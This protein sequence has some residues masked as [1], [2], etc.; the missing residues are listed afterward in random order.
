MSRLS[1][2][3]WKGHIALVKFDLRA[4]EKGVVVSVPQI[5]CRY[6]RVVETD[7]GFLRVQIK[8]A[9]G[10]ASKSSGSAIVRLKR[11][12]DRQGALRGYSAHE[13]DALVLYLPQVDKLCWLEPK[14]FVDK[15]E[16]TIRYTESKNK[17]RT[18]CKYIE[19]HEW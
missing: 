6:D 2:N 1:S 10:R 9:G 16:L 3:E 12:R 4:A 18:K 14:H 8:Y 15:A 7:G 13:I 11:P 17:Q 19:D 5:P